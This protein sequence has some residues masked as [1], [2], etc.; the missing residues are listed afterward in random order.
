[1]L[2][3]GKT[4][5]FSVQPA[6]G[7]AFSSMVSSQGGEIYGA[8]TYGFE[9]TSNQSVVINFVPIPFSQFNGT[10]EGLIY[11]ESATNHE[12]LGSFRLQLAKS[13]SFSANIVLD[14]FYYRGSASFLP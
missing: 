2:E 13:G 11:E 4:Y 1:M 5:F 3:L 7:Y 14:G 12:N 8:N 6:P 10:Y 9:M